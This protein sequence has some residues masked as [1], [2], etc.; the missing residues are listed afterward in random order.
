[1]LGYRYL[2]LTW[3][4]FQCMILPVSALFNAP[5]VHG[6]AECQHM[7]IVRYKAL[8]VPFKLIAVEFH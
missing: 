2:V 7:S 3:G 5:T 4:L 8:I 1:M 6:Q